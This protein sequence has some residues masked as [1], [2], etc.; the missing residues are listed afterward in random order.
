[1]NILHQIMRLP[2][3]R[4]LWARF[5]LGTV[6]AR[7]D[8]GIFPY[9]SCLGVPRITVV[10]FG[11][12]GGRGLLALEDASIEIER[13]IGIAIDVV[14]F[15]TG[16]GMPPPIDYRDLP[17]I[18]GEGF[19]EM[20]QD[21][22]RARLRRAEL[23]LGDVHDTTQHWLQQRAKAPLGFV[24]FDLDYYSSTKAALAIFE[25]LQDT[26]LPRVHCYFDD[27]A[28]N[29][30]GCMNPHVGELLAMSEFNSKHANRKI[31]RIEQ[32]RLARTAWERWQERM[33]AFHNFSHEQY[34]T[35]LIDRARDKFQLGL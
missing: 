22:L 2:Y 18:W 28:S 3:A 19:Y 6:R 15:D 33:F 12:A 11:V 25:G 24:A 27:I 30:L 35:L 4:G 23:I 21:K 29:D 7:V 16:K 8:Y 1:M 17:H 5:P 14:G 13:A 34:T 10:E 26:H 20:D 31:C 9:P 32:L